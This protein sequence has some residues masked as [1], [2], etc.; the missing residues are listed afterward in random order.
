MAG[1][2]TSRPATPIYLHLDPAPGQ[3]ALARTTAEHQIWALP[4]PP[5]PC[6]PSGDPLIMPTSALRV[7][8]PPASSGWTSA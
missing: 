8:P 5:R 4:C 6:S 3:Q 7:L 1:Y 2:E